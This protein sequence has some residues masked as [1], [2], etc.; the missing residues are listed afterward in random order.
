MKTKKTLQNNSIYP[1][2]CLCHHYIDDATETCQMD[3]RLTIKDMTR[4]ALLQALSWQV[5]MG[6]DEALIETPSDAASWQV[7]LADLQQQDAVK[8]PANQTQA[9][10]V[11]APPA[12]HHIPSASPLPAGP[13]AA[14][15]P[16]SSHVASSPHQALITKIASV[17]TV[18]ELKE[19]MLAFEGCDL[20]RTATNL[21]FSDGHQQSDIMII[22]EA[23]GKDEDRMGIPF[24]GR[25]GQLLDKMLG[26]VNFDRQSVY[27]TN[28]VPWR[29]P[30]NRPPTN[31]EIDMMRPFVEKHIALIKPRFLVA[32]GGTACKT[33]L[34][35]E[36]GIMKLRGQM[37]NFQTVTDVTAPLSIPLMPCLHPGFL[38]RSPH[39]KS[40]VFQDLV[41]LRKKYDSGQA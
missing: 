40:F 28:I 32:L 8:N 23:P 14:S 27:I 9:D 34:G 11:S 7:S 15:S 26:S 16:S 12:A 5:E 6:C 25:A 10:L 22:G 13:T 37:Q 30:G 39:H 3:R 38:L 24:V 17:E 19:M 21:V 2:V 4:D 29:P 20:K 33:L 36:T 1:L 18:A 35:I 31:E 41:A